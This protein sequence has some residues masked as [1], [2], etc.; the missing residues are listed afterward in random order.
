MLLH[1]CTKFSELII[2]RNNISRPK[3]CP[4]GGHYWQACCF[5]W[6]HFLFSGKFQSKLSQSLW[7]WAMWI[8]VPSHSF[9]WSSD[10]RRMSA[11]SNCSNYLRMLQ[12][13]QLSRSYT[14][15]ITFIFATKYFKT[16]PFYHQNRIRKIP[17][18]E[19]TVQSSKPK[20]FIKK[21]RR[22]NT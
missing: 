3:Y 20:P 12:K 8:D 19:K 18:F 1:N 5:G 13:W 7:I 2:N 10:I 15:R 11:F 22:L 21:T 9:P 17:K 6:Q 16:R 14:I 4:F